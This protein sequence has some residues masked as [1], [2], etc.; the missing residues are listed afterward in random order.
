MHSCSLDSKIRMTL[1]KSHTLSALSFDS[2]RFGCPKKRTDQISNPS[3]A[4]LLC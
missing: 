3:L 2:V 1:G 4:E